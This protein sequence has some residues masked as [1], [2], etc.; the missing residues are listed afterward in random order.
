MRRLAEWYDYRVVNVNV[1]VLAAGF[2]ALGITLAVMHVL[3][4]SGTLAWLTRQLGEN[5]FRLFGKEFHGEKFLI[6]V[7]TFIVDLVADV[8]V[9]YVLHWVANHMPR[10][11]A[12]HPNRGAYAGLSFMRDA[13]L[14]Q[15]ER[16]LLS[17]ILYVVALGLQSVML[18]NGYGVASATGIGFAIGLV[19]TRVL[20]TVWMLRQERAAEQRVAAGLPGPG[21]RT[22]PP[23]A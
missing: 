14:V 5:H 2:V 17:P 21:N 22:P 15:F 3:D 6:G 20:H 4:R 9:Y 13:S 7:L 12:P 8:L 10:K 23:I 19:I 11:R 16:A 18:H 1:N